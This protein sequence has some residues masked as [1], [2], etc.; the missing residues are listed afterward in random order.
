MSQSGYRLTTIITIV[1]FALLTCHPSTA[2]AGNPKKSR[3]SKG[4]KSQ[5]IPKR[6][7]TGELIDTSKMNINVAPSE[8]ATLGTAT[9]PGVSRLLLENIPAPSLAG[10]LL[11]DSTIQPVAIYFPPSYSSSK[12]R[13]PVVYFLPGFGDVVAQYLDGT[14]QGFRLQPV[15]DSLIAAGAVK[16]MIVV[17]INGRNLLG[18]SFYANSPVSGNWEN[19]VEK[20]V[21]TYIDSRYRTILRP[22]ARGIAGHSMGGY[23]A[24]DLA[25]HHPDIFGNAYCLSPGLFDENGLS[26][27][28][29]FADPKTVRDYLAIDRE[30]TA[31]NREQAATGL[32][33]ILDSL[34]TAQRWDLIF[35]MA[36]GAAFSGKPSKNAPH[37]SYP[38]SLDNNAL[39]LDTL[40]WHRWESGFGDLNQKLADS[41]TQLSDLNALGIEYGVAD[42]NS[43]I[44][45]GCQYFARLL[46]DRHIKYQMTTFAGQTPGPTGNRLTQYMLPFFS[47]NLLFQR[48]H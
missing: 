28:L 36:Y 37:I 43:W 48:P 25:M 2:L 32:G 6:N 16:E 1:F 44:P 31:M 30:L 42:E 45:K 22:S 47:Q 20:D 14:Y 18:G 10:N 13:Y 27:S 9:K 23:G 3:S 40:V 26:Q 19:F 33:R 17:V 41:R 8:S 11:G 12:L 15:M 46:T 35:T 21:V 7:S 29:M 4:H 39:A 24:L 38:Y 34:V 5:T